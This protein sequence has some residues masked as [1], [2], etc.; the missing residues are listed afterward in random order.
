MPNSGRWVRVYVSGQWTEMWVDEWPFT[1]RVGTQTTLPAES[2]TILGRD[3]KP[4]V[5]EPT[6]RLI[7]F[8]PEDAREGAR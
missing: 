7:G 2:K 3:G 5:N 6:R 1:L 8:H 4:L